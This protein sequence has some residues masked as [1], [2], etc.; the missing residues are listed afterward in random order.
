MPAFYNLPRFEQMSLLKQVTEF[1]PVSDF[2]RFYPLKPRLS[3]S[4]NDP[5]RTLTDIQVSPYLFINDHLEILHNSRIKNSV[6][7][8]MTMQPMIDDL[9]LYNLW[10]FAL[11]DNG[12]P[13]LICQNLQP[14]D[15]YHITVVEM[16]AL[17]Y[18]PILVE[19]ETP[20]RV[21]MLWSAAAFA[22]IAAALSFFKN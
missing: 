5:K 11:V 18:A 2:K 15:P 16:D 12:H 4:E 3:Y 6:V 1:A 9:Q 20:P 13:L 14:R 21:K 17:W 8:L 19:L 7:K 22:T 10:G